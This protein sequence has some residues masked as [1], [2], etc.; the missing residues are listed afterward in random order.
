MKMEFKSEVF[1]VIYGFHR[2]Y[3]IDINAKVDKVNID[4]NV[5]VD[6]RCWGIK[7]I[8]INITNVRGIVEWEVE[9]SEISEEDK[10]KLVDIGGVEY[11]N[12]LISGEIQINNN[13][14]FFGK[15]WTVENKMTLTDDGRCAPYSVEI[16]FEKTVIEVE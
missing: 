6:A 8:A 16:D 14:E 10:K 12:G 15:K 4:W 3:G 13:E 1:G 9:A 5:D 2:I 11:N 7:E